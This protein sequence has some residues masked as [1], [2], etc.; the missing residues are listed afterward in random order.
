VQWQ[1]NK[2]F[3]FLILLPI[4]GLRLYPQS[5]T[6]NEFMSANSYF[7]TDEDGDYSDW[8]ELYNY[9]TET[10][11]LFGFGLSD[12]DSNPFRWKFPAITILPDQ[13]I[14]IWAS[15]KDKTIPGMPLHTN[16]SIKV[17][18]EPLILTNPYG[19]TIC[20]VSPITLPSD[21]SYGRQPDGNDKWFFFIEPTPNAPN[22]T[23]AYPGILDHP[24]FSHQGGFYTDDFWLTISHID[25]E[26]IIYYTLDGS[27]PNPANMNVFTFTYKD[28]YPFNPRDPFGK[29]LTSTFQTYQFN[30][31]L[32]IENICARPDSITHISTTFDNNLC[33]F[34]ENPV[35]KGT[36]VRAMAFKEG[37]IKSPTITHTY[38]VTSFG[39]ERYSLPIFSL[40]VG[41]ND[42]FDYNIGIYTAG[43]DF[44][45][46][47]MANPESPI[48]WQTKANFHRIG[49]ESEKRSNLEFFDVNDNFS[50]FSHEIGFRINGYESRRRPLKSIRLYS[51]SEYGQPN[52]NYKFFKNLKDDQFKTLILR[53]S[54]QD[55][56]Q[57]M[58]RDAAIQQMVKDLIPDIQDVM[59]AIL[60]INGEYWGI[61]NLRERFD[62]DYLK[63][64]Y[65][66]DAGNIDFIVNY[67]EVREGDTVHYNETKEYIKQHGLA[68]KEHYE[69]IQ[70]R[71][72]VDN[73]RDY[74][75]INIFADNHD[76]PGNNLEYWR[77]RTSQYNPNAPTGQDGR[78]RWFVKDL[79]FGF[80]LFGL[81]E[82]LQHNMLQ[83]ATAAG[84]LEYPNPDWATFLL[85]K[86]LENEEFKI[87]FINRFADLLNTTFLP[88]VM[89]NKI[90][91]AENK[92]DIE[93]S[94]HITRWKNISSYQLWLEQMEV[95]Y[96]FAEQR[97]AYQNQH[98]IDFFDLS[99]QYS[100]EVDVSNHWFGKV[101][102]NSIEITDDTP[103]INESAYPWSGNYY[104]GIPIEVE[105]I[106]LPG[107]VFTHWSGDTTTTDPILN[108]LPAKNLY[109]KAH[110]KKNNAPTLVNYWFFDTSLPNNTPLEVI[111]ASYSLLNDAT[112]TFHSSIDGYPFY[113]GH[114][115]WRK[116]SMERRNEPTNI[117]YRPE[118]NNNIPYNLSNTKGIQVRQPF[119]GDGGENIM[120]FQLPT[121]GIRDV[122]FRFAAKD[123]GAADN[124]IIEY[125]I[126][127]EPV[128]WTSEGL[129]NPTPLLSGE[130]QLFEFDFKNIEATNDNPDFGIRIRFDG[131]NMSAD[132]GNRVT[133]NN[134]S[135]DGI[136]I[137]PDNSPPVFIA[138]I[139][140]QQCIEGNEKAILINLDKYVMDPEGDAI[141]YSFI[142]MH[143][144][145][146]Q[147]D[148]NGSILTILPIQ[149]GACNIIILVSD[150]FTEPVA[151]SFI[152]TVY[153][154]AF[155]LRK[156]K[157]SFNK[158][159]ENQP[160]N[161]F[162]EHMIFLQSDKNDPDLYD[163]LLFAYFIPH[164][165]YAPEDEQNI[166]FP[167]KNNYRTRI[168]GLDNKGIAIV[169]TNAERD[170]GGFLI[171]LD[172]REVNFGFINWTA[173]LLEQNQKKYAIRL[174]YR[175]DVTEPFRELIIKNKVL[176][177]NP[178][179]HGSLMNFLDIPLPDYIL[180]KQYV[181]LLWKFYYFSGNYG[182]SHRIRLDDINIADITY[183]PKLNFAYIHLYS[184]NNNIYISFPERTYAAID[185]YDVAG[186]LIKTRQLAGANK[187][188]IDMYPFKGIFIARIYLNND[189]YVKKFFVN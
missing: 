51:R 41:K 72:D 169:N 18:D 44:D 65:D 88:S 178:E 86:F 167:Y 67:N 120:N 147:T 156:N 180:N 189:V 103:G 140:L 135:L 173:E 93:V 71:I 148:L 171:A 101:R 45:E 114:P 52:F 81:E 63:R 20:E 141:Y 184:Y 74:Q 10:I 179:M 138:Q 108:L 121:T 107:Y 26:V 132:D 165:V 182:K 126:D 50:A 170:L 168:N 5:I 153:P 73:F 133:F 69:Y 46:W 15:G 29:F 105:A 91:E 124:L 143:P 96:H 136:V 164:N 40:S 7:I 113:A 11:N 78:W 43:Q 128:N 176:E 85:R 130:Y 13:Y 76:W 95:M 117:N 152:I 25:P 38:F 146:A 2:S 84:G 161:S 82:A 145:V 83:F 49:I 119:I 150:C 27:E 99:G 64:V 32:H 70:T 89:Q 53:N 87:S 36:V 109:L 68:E 47:R 3:L 123:E 22:Q 80:G 131:D 172:T 59:P 110:F 14:L 17:S 106:A 97:P 30:D 57:T 139:P 28:K 166:G 122:V 162:P 37:W 48:D 75:I 125:T 157:I 9:G 112:L 56:F 23:Q 58:L 21:I 33:Y 116:A 42:L 134:I 98:I 149:R 177:Y 115:N 183:V 79:D 4:I 39:R 35:F 185:I 158:W 175:F 187:Y 100:L 1:F 118:G 94:E 24:Q 154:K 61:H 8:I 19:T 188:S 163:E 142:N 62:K 31:S 34:P 151:S 155:E 92:I 186:R 104:L 160:E 90:L 102:I 6:I 159:D 16:F 127:T 137:T 174:F 54:G 181:Q 55:Y 12:D 60:F 144:Q 111:E 77:M 66:I 129:S